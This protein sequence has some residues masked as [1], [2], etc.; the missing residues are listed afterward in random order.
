MKAIVFIACVTGH[1]L[2]WSGLKKIHV[3]LDDVAA[4]LEL[5]ALIVIGIISGGASRADQ[6][7]TEREKK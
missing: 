7:E 6:A 1:W 4:G 3:G 5:L 2:L